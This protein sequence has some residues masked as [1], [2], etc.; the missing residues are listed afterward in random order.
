MSL[1]R[2]FVIW[3]GNLLGLLC[4]RYVKMTSDTTVDDL[5]ATLKA[6][7]ADEPFVQVRNPLDI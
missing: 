2:K 6:K 1:Y 3:M 7:Y 4:C 5:R